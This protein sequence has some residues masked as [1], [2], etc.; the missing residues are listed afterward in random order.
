ML[1]GRGVSVERAAEAI[2][3]T[4]PPTLDHQIRAELADGIIRLLSDDPAGSQFALTPSENGFLVERRKSTINEGADRQQNWKPV[5]VEA[6]SAAPGSSPDPSVISLDDPGRG[7]GAPPFS[8]SPISADKFGRAIGHAREKRGL[9]QKDL[10]K[11]LQIQPST[12]S[13]WEAGLS[14]PASA[15]QDKVLNTLLMVAP[16]VQVSR[17]RPKSARVVIK[18]RAQVLQYSRILIGALQEVVDY[19]QARHHNRPP[20]ELRLDDPEYLKDLSELVAELRRLNALLEQRQP[21]GKQAVDSIGHIAKYTDRFMN[22]YAKTLGNG[23]AWLT[24]AALLALLQA[25]GVDLLSHV[26][27]PH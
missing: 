4:Y 18:N 19:D 8:A 20:P 1:G 24:V 15:I 2:R 23:T 6:L 22:N 3:F 25:S 13:R 27:I 10:A 16:A 5:P 11:K 9:S 17:T 26:K 7:L 21:K 12:L 14:T